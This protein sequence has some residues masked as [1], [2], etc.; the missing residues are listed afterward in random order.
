MPDPIVL[1][2]LARVRGA[3]ARSSTWW[4]RA[5]VRSFEE[6]TLETDD[7]GAARAL[8]RSGRLG[9]IVVL[10]AMASAVVDPGTE[11]P[12][13]A[14]VK[15]DKNGSEI[16]R[17]SLIRFIRVIRGQIPAN[18]CLSQIT[19]VKGIKKD[20]TIFQICSYLPLSASSAVNPGEWLF[21][22][23]DPAGTFHAFC[24]LS[25]KVRILIQ[26]THFVSFHA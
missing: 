14:Q 7:L 20:L 15:A 18:G 2:R 4:G 24:A 11:S 17:S 5:F 22:A 8:A 23:N 9:A 21:T 3:T 10:E 26:I 19:Q 6:L 25:R 16:V 12:Q 1:A 13:M